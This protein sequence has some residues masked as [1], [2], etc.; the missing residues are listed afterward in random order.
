MSY[1]VLRYN[2]V[3]RIFLIVESVLGTSYEEDFLVTLPH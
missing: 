3:D 2:S 1:L